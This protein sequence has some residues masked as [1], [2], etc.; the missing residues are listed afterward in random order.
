MAQNLKS[1][2]PTTTKHS[3]PTQPHGPGQHWS[4]LICTICYP[5]HQITFCSSKTNWITSVRR[6]VHPMSVSSTPLIP[7]ESTTILK[8]GDVH[9]PARETTLICVFWGSNTEGRYIV[10]I[11]LLWVD[12][13]TCSGFIS[14]LYAV[15]LC[16]LFP[17]ERNGDLTFSIRFLCSAQ[18]CSLPL[19]PSKTVYLTAVLHFAWNLITQNASLDSRHEFNF[20]SLHVTF[21]WRTRGS[22][23]YSTANTAAALQNLSWLFM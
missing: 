14:I 17:Y 6:R 9:K 7:S 20:Y 23:H 10:I 11:F 22:L 1:P 8:K 3:G 4:I 16:C 2:Q 13:S 21:F 18:L 5:R 12:R 15:Y 19:I